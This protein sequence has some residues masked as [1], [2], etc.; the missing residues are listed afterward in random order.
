MPRVLILVASL[1]AIANIARP[2]VP[3]ASGDLAGEILIGE[4][5]C[6]A[7]HAAESANARLN[8]KSAPELSNAA[9]RLTPQYLQSYLADPHGSRPGS[10]MPDP[11]HGL[12][13]RSETVD[14]LTHYL[15]SRGEAPDEMLGGNESEAE[16]GK[17]LFESIGCAACHNPEG[18]Q[19]GADS[20]PLDGLARKTTVTA[21]TAF[22]QDPHKTRPSGRMPNFRLSFGEAKSLAVYL[23]REQ[24]DNPQNDEAA[25]A[26]KPGL[27]YKLF[28]GN[29]INKE[30]RLLTEEPAFTGTVANF[31]L[32]T[33]DRKGRN[34]QYAYVYDGSIRIEQDGNYQFQMTSDDSS[35]MWIN[36]KQIIGIPGAHPMT[37]KIGKVDLKAG[38]HSIRVIFCQDGGGAGLEVR[39][40]VP[41]GKLEAIPN[42]LLSTS[43]GKPM[44]PLGSIDFAVDEA[45]A[46]AGKVA[47]AK[48]GCANCHDSAAGS[49]KPLAKLK[50]GGCLAPNPPAAAPNF[51]LSAEQRAAISKA[52]AGKLSDPLKPHERVSRTLA[53]FNCNACHKRGNI[54]GP[55]QRDALFTMTEHL[56][57]GDEGRFPPMLSGVG[58]KLRLAALKGIIHHGQQHIRPYMATRMPSFAESATGALAEDFVAADAKPEDLQAVSFDS[59]AVKDGR[60]LV[61]NTGL[62]CVNCHRIAG[63]NSLGINTIDIASVGQRLN[64]AWLRRF[65]DDPPGFNPGTVM[66][67]FWPNGQVVI[68]D[69]A[70]KTA[71]SQQ[72]AIYNYLSLGKSMPLPPGIQAKAGGDVLVPAGE[73]LVLRTFVEGA[74]PRGIVI[75]YP[76]RVHAMFDAN[77]VHMVKFW[78][79]DFF[80]PKGAWS[81]RNMTFNGPAGSD[82]IDIPGPA[83]AQLEALDSMWPV[84]E[85]TAR[86]IGGRFQGY[87]LDKERI[88]IFKYQLGEVL[89]EE[90][91]APELILGGA[92]ITRQFTL[93]GSAEGLFA[94]LAGGN[95]ISEGDNGNFIVDGKLTL[96]FKTDQKPII[97]NAKDGKEL[98][99]AIPDTAKFSFEVL[100]SW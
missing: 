43:G 28:H 77:H 36:D 95:S 94:K 99:L 15:M 58:A 5:N 84:A 72:N 65:L 69:L 49:A 90:R 93:A 73:P 82:V 71:E 33:P 56:D 30:K 80:D 52:L 97:R 7:C 14:A 59:A 98:L 9:G 1:A 10:M 89:I 51:A 75:G 66:P 20:I 87:R 11:L 76:E 27:A 21:L 96:T 85:R 88:P 3:G 29:Y 92:A 46:A 35:F 70:S 19:Y 4:L 44:L 17:K 16:A 18:G 8:T 23:L 32:D 62:G 78:R 74:G 61:G 45:K 50:S 64:P 47:Y 13:D 100:Y 40:K 39:W 83:F 86:E 26:A 54:G 2:I 34:Q 91:L 37:K 67:P 41:G 63:H 6:V 53:K 79:G 55:Q 12:T 81:G 31:S 68:K 57:L 24:L 42:E 48:F 25:P 22:L 38:S 60:K